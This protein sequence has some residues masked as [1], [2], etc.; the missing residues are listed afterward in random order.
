M[1]SA[2]LRYFSGGDGG[3]ISYISAEDPFLLGWEKDRHKG[4][5]QEKQGLVRGYA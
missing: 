5:R 2:T 4:R 3:R 1:R